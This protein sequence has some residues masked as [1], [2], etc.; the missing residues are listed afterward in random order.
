MFISFRRLCCSLT[1]VAALSLVGTAFAADWAQ[2]RGPNSD[3]VSKETGL[4]KQWPAEGPKQLWSY[5][6]GAGYSCFSVVGDRVF[7][8][9]ERDGG[10]WAV[11]VNTTDGKEVWKAQIGPVDPGQGFAGPRSTPVIDGD[12]VYVLNPLGTLTCLNKADGKEV[13]KENV[14]TLT[15]AKNLR[16][17]LSSSVLVDGDKLIA[18]VGTSD[19]TGFIALNKKDHK[20]IWRT[21]D[22]NATGYSTPIV[23]T[24]AGKKQYVCFAGNGAQGLDPENG[25][26]LWTVPWKTMSDVNA[27]TPIIQGNKV[28]ISSGYNVGAGLYEINT[29]GS[30]KELWK[31]KSLRAHF[32]S[33]ILVGDAVYGYD[34]SVFVCLDFATGNVKWS[35]KEYGKGTA[36]VADGL[37]YVL[38]EKGNL[39]L[40]KPNPAQFEKISE[41]PTPLSKVEKP[42]CWTAPVV[43]NG[44]LFV[45][46]EN[47]MVCYDVKGK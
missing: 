6:I 25:N 27:A 26:V 12:K 34:D 17:H 5:P 46:D 40:V 35:Q 31:N 16:W 36:V 41:F 18:P 33:P 47:Q 4:L 10:Q 29:D 13:W 19:S 8:I 11:C 21:K 32:T 20:E 23:A 14:M 9:G 39:A 3:G 37:L 43:A 45:R 24:L 44:K 42:R 38:G 2:W 1:T 22:A 7:T 28:L 30:T 15:G